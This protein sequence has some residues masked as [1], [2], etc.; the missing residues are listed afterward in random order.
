MLACMCAFTVRAGVHRNHED[1]ISSS[2]N[3]LATS[4]SILL[5]LRLVALLSCD[6]MRGFSIELSGGSAKARQENSWPSVQ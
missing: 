3:S 2:G 6:A 5:L 4:P 1:L